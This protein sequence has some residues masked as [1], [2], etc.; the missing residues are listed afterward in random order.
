[1]SLSSS[2]PS[3][4]FLLAL[5]GVLACTKPDASPGVVTPPTDQPE[6]EAPAEPFEN[7][8]GMWMPAQLADRYHVETLAKLGLEFDP[9]A[10]SKPLEFPL[11]AVISLGGCSA[12]FVSEKGLIIT[13]HHCVTGAL[14]YNSKE[15]QNL[16]DTG[17]LAK[18]HA[19]ELWAGPTQKI[20]VT[21][22][23]TDVTPAM[24]DGLDAIPDPQ[25]RWEEVGKRSS[26]IAAKCE[27][28]KTDTRCTVSSFFEG[29]Q[30]FLI[31]QLELRD[32]R[33]VHAPHAGVGVF[34]GEVDNWRWPRH[35]GDY[36]F[37]RA[38]VGPDGQPADYSPNNVPY[39]PKYHIEIATDDLDPGDLVFVAGYPGR[40]NRLKTASDVEIAVEWFY[41]RRI[42]RMQ[43]YIATLERVTAGNEALAI[44]AEPTLRSLHN[45]LTNTIGQLEGLSKGLAAE[46]AAQEQALR[47]WIAADAQRKAKYGTVLDELAALD[48]ETVPTREHDAALEELADASML[49]VRARDIVGA[50]KRRAEGAGPTDKER[51]KYEQS[52][53]V[54][55]T[56][57]AKEIDRAVLELHIERAAKLPADQQP[58]LLK[59]LAGPGPYD[60]QALGEALDKLYAKKATKLDD[61]KQ[62]MKLYSKATLEELE[63]SKDPFIKAAL[64]VKPALETVQAR[65][66][67]MAGKLAILRPLYIEALREFAASK[68]E[69]LAPDAN[70]TLRVTYGTV[71]GYA[72][73]PGAPVYEPFTTASQ[74]LAKHTGEEPFNLPE[75]VRKGIEAKNF[76]PYVDPEIGELPINFLTDLDITGG[77][78]GS[79]TFNARGE[80]VGLVFDGNYEAMASGWVFMPEITRAIH[81]DVRSILWMMDA[82]DGADW[83]LEEM[84]VE[85]AL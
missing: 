43:Q 66:A 38:Y 64:A 59:L 45:G 48:A 72:P 81:V 30:Y 83:L 75:A 80:L 15:G 21:R 39:Q 46:K 63:K 31:E 11:G 27:E 14:N 23:F 84:G 77:N 58:E 62:V 41:P 26:E 78:S 79:T 74:M 19:E 68:G 40:T 53:T 55:Q 82:I 5:A 6:A 57:F 29:A 10:L 36:S 85:P 69:T 71:R 37:Y 8:G 18:N 13:N 24:L 52:L 61:P 9:L 17:F 3:R 73:Q 16:H 4:S 34:G 51:T 2:S 20:W 25:K 12:S 76:G 60:I 44:K 28:G 54:Q 35:T 33:I 47:D 49:L 22:A 7:P 70:S 65:Q 56:R 50:A 32:I 42:A 67:A 1:M